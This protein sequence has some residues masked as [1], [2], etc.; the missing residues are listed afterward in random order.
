MSGRDGGQSQLERTVIP[1]DASNTER[2]AGT[3]DIKVL[4]E[5]RAVKASR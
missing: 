3:G 5:T 4:R 1:F 2:D